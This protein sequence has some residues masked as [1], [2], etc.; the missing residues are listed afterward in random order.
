VLGLP[1]AEACLLQVRSPTLHAAGL[2]LHVNQHAERLNYVGEIG[3]STMQ[4]RGQTT[5]ER[6]VAQNAV[7]VPL[8]AELAGL[9]R[10]WLAPRE[11][12]PKAQQRFPQHWHVSL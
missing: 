9:L 11:L 10:A 4:G 3:P 6:L 12:P 7:T 2:S 1:A 5:P 8:I